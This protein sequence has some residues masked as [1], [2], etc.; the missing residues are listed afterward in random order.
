MKKLSDEV[1]FKSLNVVYENF[2][3]YDLDNFIVPSFTTEL[4]TEFSI[5]GLV[6]FSNKLRTETEKL[7]IISPK[8]YL[9][10]DIINDTLK[11]KL[12]L[13]LTKVHTKKTF[14]IIDNKVYNF[15]ILRKES[16]NTGKKRKVERKVMDIVRVIGI[17]KT[18]YQYLNPVHVH[19]KSENVIR[20]LMLKKNNKYRFILRSIIFSSNIT[21]ETD[22][23]FLLSDGL[24]D[25]RKIFIKDSLEFGIGVCYLSEIDDWKLIKGQSKKVQVV[26]D[27]SEKFAGQSKHF[28][29]NF[30]TGNI[31][32]ILKFSITLV[33]G[34]KKL[35]KFKD[36]EESIPIINFDIE[37]LE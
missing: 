12:N 22:T 19:I 4:Q 15:G 17:Q 27:D 36:G 3:L 7:N 31:S 33:D 18:E 35:I 2:F 9:R 5:Y 23:I 10:F 30:I 11:N 8:N 14:E 29:F 34:E 26:F 37:I 1:N 21:N 24:N 13:E 32:D 25:A 20:K 28:A 16:E 6:N